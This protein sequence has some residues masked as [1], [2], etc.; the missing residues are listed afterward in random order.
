MLLL[1]KIEINIT[2]F[3][4]QW[5][6]RLPILS[7]P[8]SLSFLGQWMTN[9]KNCSTFDSKRPTAAFNFPN[10]NELGREQSE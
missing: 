6:N 1:Q 4:D 8:T 9:D 5:I 7:S 3:F 10:H 2:Y